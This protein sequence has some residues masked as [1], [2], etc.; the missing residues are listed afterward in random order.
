MLNSKQFKKILPLLMALKTHGSDFDLASELVERICGLVP[1]PPVGELSEKLAY[2]AELLKNVNKR[3]EKH[4]WVLPNWKKRR[5]LPMLLWVREEH[6]ANTKAIELSMANVYF[7]RF[8]EASK[9]AT[10]GTK[11]QKPNKDSVENKK[12]EKALA[13]LLGHLI[14]RKRWNWRKMKLERVP[15]H[16]REVLELGKVLCECLPDVMKLWL[17]NYF[18][19][20]L[21][22]FI[23]M[24]PGVFGSS[25]PTEQAGGTYQ[26]AK[27]IFP[28]GQGWIAILEDVALQGVHG[29]FEKVCDTEAVTIWLFLEHQ[30][31]KAEASK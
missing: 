26:Q 30:K 8:A 22:I 28:N 23:K 19:E 1:Q 9:A 10:V 18:E 12:Y 27:G 15:Y 5:F 14:I 11:N 29:D 21:K 2:V 24:F 6:F 20:Q 3:V 16:S 7:L 4:I 17:V 13:E 31:I 25:A